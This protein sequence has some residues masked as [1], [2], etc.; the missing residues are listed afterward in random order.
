MNRLI[1]TATK[2]LFVASAGIFLAAAS[3]QQP[4]T[5]PAT[6]GASF[7]YLGSLE[8]T[9]NVRIGSTPVSRAA[10][11]A[12]EAAKSEKWLADIAHGEALMKAGD[13]NGAI[14]AFQQ[15]IAS[16]PDDGLAYRRMAEAYAASGKLPEASQTFHKFLVEGFGPGTNGGVVDTA[17]EWTEY[18]LV[19]VKTNQPVEAAQMYN[20]AAYLLD[21]ED[22]EN[23]GGKPA[24]KVLFP[25]IVLGNALP[26]QVPYT[27]EHLQALADSLLAY[28][29]QGFWSYKEIKAYAQE[30]AKLYPDSA[31]V[32]YYLGQVLSGSR[33]AVLDSPA[34]DK[35]AAQAAY[36]EDKKGEVAAYQKAVELGDEA[37]AAEAKKW[38]NVPR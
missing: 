5:T 26:E 32:Q 1:S 4:S 2:I 9:R 18:A 24:L 23:H 37:T 12:M 27:P 22:S 3:A 8:H 6:S 21:Y 35:A 25:E 15:M 34:K 20:H 33:Y 10:E 31:P 14:D 13:M 30:A 19:L 29:Q 38:L 28:K 7:P 17:D 16:K 36:E 11:A